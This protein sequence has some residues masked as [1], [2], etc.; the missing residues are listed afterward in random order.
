VLVSQYDM[1]W[2]LLGCSGTAMTTRGDVNRQ[3]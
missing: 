2:R 3:R 1:R